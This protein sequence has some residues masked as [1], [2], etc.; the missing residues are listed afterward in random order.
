MLLCTTLTSS[1]AETISKKYIENDNEDYYFDYVG[2]IQL[3]HPA[4][5]YRELNKQNYELAF[6]AFTKGVEFGD[7]DSLYQIGSAYYNGK[8]TNLNKVE[9]FKWFLKAASRGH[10][11]AQLQI[12]YQY[13]EGVGIEK[14][15]ILA[16]AWYEI[17]S[18]NKNTTEMYT[19]L[20][21]T[22]SNNL[23]EKLSRTDIFRAKTIARKCTI[24]NYTR[25]D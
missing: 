25:C 17:A 1:F 7:L 3:R 9:A 15:S 13:S 18:L 5:G 4:I 22:S 23:Q 21:K 12:A 20:A 10:I 19:L 24:T 6:K 11:S 14:D 16:L 2:D 8:G